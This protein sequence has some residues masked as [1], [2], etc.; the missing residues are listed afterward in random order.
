MILDLDAGNTRLKWRLSG[1]DGKVLSRG[2]VSLEDFLAA[3]P[4]AEGIRNVRAACVR[5]AEIEAR[6]LQ[7]SQER[8]GVVAGIARVRPDEAGVRVAYA[9]VGKLGVDRWLCLLAAFNPQQNAVCVI[10]CGSA[11]TVDLVDDAGQ[12][13][14]GLIAPGLGLMQKSL[15]EGTD[16]VRFAP[17]ALEVLDLAPGTDTAGCVRA[18]ISTAAVGLVERA[19]REY[20]AICPRARLVITGGDAPRI[21]PLLA[22]P[23][24]E[25]PELVLDGLGFALPVRGPAMPG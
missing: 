24:L 16:R 6:L 11:I 15:L 14:G 19:V 23:P 4:P 12:H 25:R 1:A 7:W 2:A 17:D 21:L 9:D 22:E 8:C 18:G 3:G 13:R 20:R 10:Q 5:G